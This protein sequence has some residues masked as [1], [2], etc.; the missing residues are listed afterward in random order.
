MVVIYSKLVA[1][2]VSSI[3]TLKIQIPPVAHLNPSDGDTVADLYVSSK[4]IDRFLKW[5]LLFLVGIICHSLLLSSSNIYAPWTTVEMLSLALNVGGCLLR[6]WCFSSLGRLF[7]FEVG[8]RREHPLIR[9]GPYR[10]L[11]HPSYTGAL[12]ASIGFQ[13]WLGWGCHVLY[14]IPFALMCYVLIFKRMPNEEAALKAHFTEK[15][16]NEYQSKRWRLVPLVY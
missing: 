10:Y 5:P 7:T 14:W 12:L 6:L 11:I 2:L 15:V 1:L 16:W 3:L 4:D 13:V 9:T 8:F